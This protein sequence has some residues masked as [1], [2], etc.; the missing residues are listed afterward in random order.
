MK[1]NTNVIIGGI[2]ILASIWFG[3][4]FLHLTVDTWASFPT[5]LTMFVGIGI[6]AAMVIFDIA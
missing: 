2:I 3:A 5:L 6:G 4:Y 1:K